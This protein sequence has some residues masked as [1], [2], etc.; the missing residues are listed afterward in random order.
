MIDY[1]RPHSNTK[2]KKNKIWRSL[3]SFAMGI[4][5]ILLFVGVLYGITKTGDYCKSNTS[6]EQYFLV[7]GTVVNV[8]YIAKPA[9]FGPDIKE[10]ILKFDDGRI[11]VIHNVLADLVLNK[12]IKIYQFNTSVWYEEIK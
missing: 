4:L 12:K 11:H 9:T 3:G 6:T 2:P 5:C 10:T 7:E 1:D 8:E